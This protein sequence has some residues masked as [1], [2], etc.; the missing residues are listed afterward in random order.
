[1][2]I[3]GEQDSRCPIQ[4]IKRF[5]EK[6]SEMKHPYVFLI[7]ER[8]GHISALFKWEENIPLFTEIVKYLKMNL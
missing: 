1:M 4:P 5:V 3:A 8:A 6:L 7:E 2:I